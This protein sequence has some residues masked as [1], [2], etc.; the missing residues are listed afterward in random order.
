MFA[1]VFYE[2]LKMYFKGYKIEITNIVEK[3]GTLDVGNL[4]Y[5]INHGEEFGRVDA[6][7]TARKYGDTKM[8]NVILTAHLHSIKVLE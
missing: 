4:H 3:I 1:T 6:E 2:M 8:Q 5:I 7:K